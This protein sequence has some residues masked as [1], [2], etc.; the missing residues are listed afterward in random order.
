MKSVCLPG[1]AFELTRSQASAIR[2]RQRG[3]CGKHS[4]ELT[5]QQRREI[6][7]YHLQLVVV[8][9]PTNGR[10][11][12]ESRQLDRAF[13]LARMTVAGSKMVISSLVSVSQR[14]AIF[15][16]ERSHSLR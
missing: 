10:C 1:H 2:A 5:R 6:A 9:R 14:F 12:A 11:S 13:R 8:H 16:H 4:P 3:C 7:A 15:C